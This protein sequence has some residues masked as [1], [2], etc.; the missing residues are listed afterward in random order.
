MVKSGNGVSVPLNTPFEEI[1]AVGAAKPSGVR[2]AV[3]VAPDGWLFVDVK[4]G[5]SELC[6]IDPSEDRM[7]ATATDI[8]AHIPHRHPKIK[9]ISPAMGSRFRFSIGVFNQMIPYSVV[10]GI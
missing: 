4:V 2:V 7:T 6:G 1:V 10:F 5:A 8:P 3:R 9:M